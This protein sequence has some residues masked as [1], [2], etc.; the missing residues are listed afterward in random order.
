MAESSAREPF[1]RLDTNGDGVV[2][3]AEISNFKDNKTG[4][5]FG[6]VKICLGN[7]YCGMGASSGPGC[8]AV[9]LRRD[10]HATGPVGERPHPDR[11]LR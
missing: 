10:A 4:T 7:S 2:T 8:T 6:G 1:K 9:R 3:L 11:H 5:Y